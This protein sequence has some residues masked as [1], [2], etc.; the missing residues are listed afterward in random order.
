MNNI[1]STNETKIELPN[2]N[3]ATCNK[4]G[5]LKLNGIEGEII[6]KNTLLVPELTKNLISVRH[7][8]ELGMETT[9]KDGECK[10]YQDKR[11]ILTGV[12]KNGLYYL[13]KTESCNM[14][15]INDYEIWH[16]RLGHLN[17]KD[18][19]KL[20]NDEE[21]EIK[22][23]T[24]DKQHTCQT[25][26]EA[27]QTRENV[28]KS[29]MTANYPLELIHSDICGPMETTT[30]NG[31]RYFITF[32]DDYTKYTYIYI[33]KNKNEAF[34]VFKR[35]KNE[36]E[37]LHNKR[38][39]QLR[40]DNGMEY[41]SK[42]FNNYLMEHGIT[43]K[44]TN[45]YSPN[46]NGVAER[47]N[48]TLCE[49]GRA[50]L[51]QSNLEKQLW[52]EAVSTSNFLRN[53]LLTKGN[54]GMKSPY[55][56]WFNRKPIYKNLKVF[57]CVAYAHIKQERQKFDK[58]S[59]KCIFI[60]YSLDKNGYR[61]Y[62]LENN[63]VIV[64]RDVKFAENEFLKDNIHKE[65]EDVIEYENNK[66]ITTY[67]NEESINDN[68]EVDDNDDEDEDYNEGI[69]NE[70]SI[71]SK[72][73]LRSRNNVQY[74]NLTTEQEVPEFYHEVMKSPDKDKWIAAM[75]DEIKS[76]NENHTWIEIED[77]EV[78]KN[79]KII[80]SRWV[81][82]IKKNEKNEIIKYKARVVAKGNNQEYQINYNEV[83][84]PVIRM[85]TIRI[86]L[87]IANNNDLIIEQMDVNTAF[88]YGDLEEEV[89]MKIPKGVKT[90]NK[91]CKL[92]KS[93][94]GLKQ[95]SRCWNKNIDTYLK[96]NGFR[97]VEAD[98][99]LY[100]KKKN[101][102]VTYIALYVDDIIICT[103]DEEWL[104]EI[105]ESLINKY[106]MKILGKLKWFLGIEIIKSENTLSMN[107]SKYI[108]DIITRF[109]MT[110]SKPV[111]TP[112]EGNT[113][114]TKSMSPT[115]DIE[116]NEMKDI[117]YRE[118]VGSLNYLSTCTRPD[119]AF[120]VSE[121]SR[122]NQNPGKQHWLAVKRIIKY[123]IGTK[124]LK[125][126]FRKST[127]NNII[128]YADADWAGDHDSRKST[129]GNLFFYNGLISWKSTKQ[130]CIALSTVEAEYVSIGEASKEAYWLYKLSKQLELNIN[131]PIIIN[132]DN[133]GT[134]KLIKNPVFH[135]RTKHIDTRYHY[136]RN[137]YEENYIDIKYCQTTEMLADIM[138]KSLHLPTFGKLSKQLF[139]YN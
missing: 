125:L 58:K 19:I 77:E 70:E 4:K 74:I 80:G 126:T 52:G 83:F 130:S 90:N 22:F 135:K 75:N 87:S 63:E 10:I 15:N 11:L 123:L 136:I 112:M 27:K 51:F 9:F 5:E 138:T 114:L 73:N 7:M 81:Y 62:N 92:N 89:Y 48:R 3:E 21:N 108:N 115:N 2:G 56:M 72:Y 109:N 30:L 67:D 31:S 68:D 61:L 49:M 78:I 91:I 20:R 113:R 96:E 134:I 69:G 43:R 99:C 82:N 24:P 38:I 101:N 54:G 16:K 102:K 131:L 34:E 116:A 59:T 65:V 100:I 29:R 33:L 111:G 104:N 53:R 55:E 95:A 37:N 71:K 128:G 110:E 139:N 97:N 86:L 76:L 8:D 127:E 41:I 106:K 1:E 42:E 79:N 93:L 28:I 122:Y 117:P 60:G 32:I 26:V 129:S 121:V 6:I 64:S 118:A 119:I 105:K 98:P 50:L 25:C 14:V 18:M 84:S 46:E 107:Q 40:S 57:G 137:L 17:L 66:Y 13:T 103:P 39:K 35:Y 44:L 120:A 45:V 88:L 133:Q 124:D 12:N 23:N 47:K 36:V 94:Y 132:E 85:L